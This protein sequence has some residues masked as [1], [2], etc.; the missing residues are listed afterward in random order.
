MSNQWDELCKRGS[1]PSNPELSK[2]MEKISSQQEIR[3]DKEN[4]GLLRELETYLE[5]S[6]EGKSLLMNLKNR[7]EFF[8]QDLFQHLYKSTMKK[9]LQENGS[10][11]FHFCFFFHIPLIC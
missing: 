11:G 3:S 6:K 9:I 5:F 2:I 10:F 7:K 8:R 1:T 4:E